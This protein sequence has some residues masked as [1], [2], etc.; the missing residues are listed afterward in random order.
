[1]PVSSASRVDQ[2]LALAAAGFYVFPLLP[3]R[4]TPPKGMHFKELATRDPLAI[5]NFFGCTENNIGI[6]TG[7][8]ADGEAL[9]VVD[10]DNKGEKRGSETLLRLE[11][12]GWD[13]PATLTVNTPTGGQ[14]LFYSVSAPVRQGA[15]V[16]GPAV[17]VRSKG[18][19]VV[20]AGSSVGAGE[21][22][23]RGADPVVRAPEW[24]VLRCGV[25]TESTA[26]SGGNAVVAPSGIE[27]A[28]HYLTNEAPA[29]IKGQGGDATAYAVAA[30]VKDFGVDEATCLE[31]MLGP[32]N[33]RSPP[34]WS[35]E[36]LA[37]KV[38]NA[39]A[40]GNLPVG[41]A[42][43]EAV[44]TPVQRTA[45]HHKADV[46]S[47]ERL[48]AAAVSEDAVHP[49]DKLNATYAFVVAGGG[50]HILFETTDHEAKY[51]LEH[52]ASGTFHA[53]HAAEVIQVGKSSKPITEE[54]MR[55]K[56]RRSYDGLVFMPGL[57]APTRFY[58]LWRGFAV[59]PYDGTHPHLHPGHR[60]VL[61]F[62]DHVRLNVCAADDRLNGWLV[63]F[64]A[65]MVQRP[66]EKPL[67]ALVFRGG[68]GVG[69]GVVV[70]TVSA[71]L[72]GHAL[73]TSNRRY[74]V[75]NFNGHLE[76][77]LLFTLDEAFWS[78]DKQA[79]GQLKDLITGDHHVIEHKGKEPYTVANRTRIA[80]I[81]N[82]DW[83][84]PAS[85]DERRFAVFDVGDGRKQDRLFFQSMREGMEA[86]G[87]RLLLRYLLDLDLAGFDF[88][89]APLTAGLA[90]QKH[91]S[92]DAFA[93]WWLACLT[94]GKLVGGDF[95][96]T[97]PLEAD[98]ER[99][100]A[101]FRRHAK[102]RRVSGWMPDDRSMGRSLK[103]FAPSVVPGRL[104]A[105]YTYKMPTLEIARRE[106]STY[107]GHEV[108]WE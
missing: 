46:G 47:A 24:L 82:E 17:D 64:F 100:R 94:D 87:Y 40:Y 63:R 58:N 2:A 80:I 42:A 96:T 50:S 28:R 89:A 107:I 78:G 43:P 95:E 103:K 71:L 75:G 29:S 84:V 25:R 67:V 11:L 104:Q 45:P 93:S 56:G 16:L 61:D 81:G 26:S 60:A 74:L 14:H 22:A 38:R 18:G 88:N 39:Y 59:E 69:K 99:F 8:F 83:L 101:A 62:L 34:G 97:W 55:W 85:H 57:T 108:S 86:G 106:W 105:G 10:V 21:Y 102:E 98:R 33:E 70:R 65:Q 20:A 79:E 54:W 9:L 27:R 30:H 41:A 92:L 90:D 23:V 13:L 32:W 15:N 73:L 48:A 1:M 68:K 35:P 77:L 72:G 53:K 36:R 52:L 91:A 12:E 76:N 5:E 49:F 31:L 6:Y 7:R 51:K 4:K 19:Y 66:W 37:I 3:G 44:F